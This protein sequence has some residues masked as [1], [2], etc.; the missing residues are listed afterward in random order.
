MQVRS[1]QAGAQ[2][3][4]CS[5][6]GEG[7][8]ERR[9]EGLSR[10]HQ[11][12]GA[13]PRRASAASTPLPLTHPR[14]PLPSLPPARSQPAPGGCRPAGAAAARAVVACHVSGQLAGGAGGGRG[15]GA[16]PP[17]NPA[18]RQGCSTRG[19]L[20]AAGRAAAAAAVGGAGAFAAG[21]RRQGLAGAAAAARRR[22]TG[23]WGWH[24]CIWLGL[25]AIALPLPAVTPAINLHLMV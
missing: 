4:C 2:A 8:Q 5:W 13:A 22:G 18:G 6:G 9:W 10:A 14:V 21:R 16:L 24:C 7:V 17:R 19:R 12:P 15:G 23:P 3:A 20:G 25:A 1:G 11:P